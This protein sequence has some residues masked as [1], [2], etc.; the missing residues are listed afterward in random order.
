[1]T[2]IPT[3]DPEP[4]DVARETTAPRTRRARLVTRSVT[5]TL[6]GLASIA[7]LV[8]LFQFVKQ[9]QPQPDAPPM[10]SGSQSVFVASVPHIRW[11][12]GLADELESL[13]SDLEG[14]TDSVS[15]T[16]VELPTKAN[17]PRIEPPR[18]ATD[19]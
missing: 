14:L 17:A 1:A 4:L 10:A 6:G 8:G 11:H 19:K 2:A 18:E 7:L 3:S 12:D 5:A 16:E 9:P 13:R 15:S